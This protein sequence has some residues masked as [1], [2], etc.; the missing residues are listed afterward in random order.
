MKKGFQ[1]AVFLIISIGFYQSVVAQTRDPFSDKV[2]KKET[3]GVKKDSFFT[4]SYLP[5]KL[6]FHQDYL[7]GYSKSNEHIEKEA[8]DFI[9]NEGKYLELFGRV[10]AKIDVINE[11]ESGYKNSRA[12]PQQWGNPQFDGLRIDLV[13]VFS[14][15]ALFVFHYRFRAKDN[16]YQESKIFDERIFYQL[17]LRNNSIQTFKATPSPQKIGS[18]KNLIQKKLNQLYLVVTEKVDVFEAK[19]LD[20]F[21]HDKINSTVKEIDYSEAKIFPYV[22][23]I[24]IEFDAFSSSSKIFDGK[25]FRL[26]IP[27]ADR[28]Y[29]LK[30]FPHLKPF[31]TQKPEVPSPQDLAKLEQER[32]GYQMIASRKVDIESFVNKNDSVKS[33]EISRFQLN[34]G[35]E[36]TL[37]NKIRI[38]F[39]AQ[40][41]RERRENHNDNGQTNYG[42]KTFYNAKN[43]IE[44]RLTSQSSI[45]LELFSY[46][47]ETVQTKTTISQ[48]RKQFPDRDYGGIEIQ[49]QHFFYNKMT[50]YIINLTPIDERPSTLSRPNPSFYSR[51]Y[52]DVIHQNGILRNENGGIIEA[53]AAD[54]RSHYYAKYDA[55]NRLKLIQ[56]YD[57]YQL[58]NKKTFTYKENSSLPLKIYDYRYSNY[59][60]TKTEYIYNWEFRD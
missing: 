6:K 41:R 18:L 37:L 21:L 46:D 29:F 19:K 49:Q 57:G 10:N 60:E 2:Y 12:Q 45:T 52:P 35:G 55:E 4:K 40:G 33:V 27:Y 53:H 17:N 32:W 31:F 36:K 30:T 50:K 9:Q 48:S 7:K 58:K 24:L 56:Q 15:Q 51:N 1:I 43:Q 3:R 47:N 44:S 26:F 23:G 25:A 13:G 20:A 54:D 11:L 22:F 16:E 28:G 59:N 34:D 5:K 38:Y 42:Q 14:G 39:D 8:L